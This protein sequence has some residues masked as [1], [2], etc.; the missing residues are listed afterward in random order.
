MFEVYF[1]EQYKILGETLKINPFSFK[2]VQ[3]SFW[4]RKS[5][6]NSNWNNFTKSF[7]KKNFMHVDKVLST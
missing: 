7:N 3:D 1:N 5:Y 2:I 4:E 6:Q